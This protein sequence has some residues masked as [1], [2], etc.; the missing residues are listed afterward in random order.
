MY[1][2]KSLH[3]RLFRTCAAGP[4][5]KGGFGGDGARA[6]L[7]K[8]P[9]SAAPKPLSWPLSPTY[10]LEP[11]PAPPSLATASAGAGAE[12]LSSGS[13]GDAVACGVPAG[14][15]A[16][17]TAAAGDAAGACAVWVGCCS[18]GP[19]YVCMYVCMHVCTYVCIHVMYVCM[20]VC[21]MYTWI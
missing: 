19:I 10:A 5:L 3:K 18:G 9:F 15:E 2:I 17:G 14:G 12:M 16:T 6:P 20:H 7:S 21:M 13:G 4:P 11:P 8:G 1:Y